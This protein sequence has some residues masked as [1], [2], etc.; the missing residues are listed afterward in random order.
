MQIKGARLQRI[1]LDPI[2][3]FLL[4]RIVAEC[5]EKIESVD[6]DQWEGRKTDQATKFSLEGILAPIMHSNL[7]PIN[8]Q[9]LQQ[10]V[11]HR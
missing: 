4:C 8:I 3:S 2:E 5:D 9:A 7:M 10:P 11:E 6:D 1:Y